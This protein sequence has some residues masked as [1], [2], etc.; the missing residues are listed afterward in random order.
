VSIHGVLLSTLAMVHPILASAQSAQDFRGPYGMRDPILSTERAAAAGVLLFVTLAA[1]EE[2]REESQE[3]RNSLT[4][5][6]GRLGNA[7]GDSRYVL[8][9]LGAGY[10]IGRLTNKPGLSRTAIRAGEA[11]ILAG[12]VAAALKYAVG[13]NRP[14][15]EGESDRFQPFGGPASFPSGHT[16]VAFAV[17]TAIADETP[18]PWTDLALYSLATA[19]AFGRVNSDRH[20]TSDVLAGAL[21]GHLTGRWLSRRRGL[22][23]GP[24]GLGVVLNF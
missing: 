11:T 18:D 12:S 2:L 16:T 19:T 21:V 3:Y 24:G 20:W 5:T 8:P 6:V 14:S 10:L 7:F 13:R 17:A 4:N 22:T 9:A 1:D 23:V 15:G